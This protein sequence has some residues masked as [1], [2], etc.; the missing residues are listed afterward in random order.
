MLPENKV[1]FYHGLVCSRASNFFGLKWSIFFFLLPRY[2]NGLGDYPYQGS[3]NRYWAPYRLLTG[4]VPYHIG[5]IPSSKKLRKLPLWL[6]CLIRI[7]LNWT[8]CIG[9]IWYHTGLVWI[10]L[11]GSGFRIVFHS[12]A[13][14]VLG[15]DGK[16]GGSG[17][18]R[19]P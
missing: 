17:W 1:L 4:T 8:K 2:A 3:L 10:F 19:K 6:S 9:T 5:P 14:L 18:F 7:R 12:R 11:N 16:P 13:I 15:R